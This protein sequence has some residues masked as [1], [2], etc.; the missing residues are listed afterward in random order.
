MREA[1]KALVQRQYFHAEHLAEQALRKAHHAHD[2]ERLARI[3][4]PLLEARRQKRDL[5]FDAAKA[6]AVFLVA[7]DL[8]AGKKILPG[9]YLIAPPRV[10]I[11]GRLLREEADKRE[12]PV[13]IAVREPATRDGL[14]PVVALGPVTIRAKV[15]PPAPAA[16]PVPKKSKAKAGSIAGAKPAS[17]SVSKPASAAPAPQHPV[18]KPAALPTPE[19]FITANEALGDAA[20]ASAAGASTPHALVDALYERLCAL[21]DHEKLHQELLAAARIAAHTPMK[22][23]HARRHALLDLEDDA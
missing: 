23:H 14:W 5:A 17:K 11:D 15:A 19:W 13:I 18:A 22:P 20:I 7:S 21:P 16:A 8:P 3:L 6:G 4:L 12:I 9:C 1:S 2:Y 10:G